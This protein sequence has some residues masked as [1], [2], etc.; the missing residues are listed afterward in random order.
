MRQHGISAGIVR[1]GLM[2]VTRKEVTTTLR[3]NFVMI[4]FRCIVMKD[5]NGP[6]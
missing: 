5:A 1:N 6:I 2:E 4:V 3:M